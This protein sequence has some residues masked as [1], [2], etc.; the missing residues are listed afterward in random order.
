MN[1]DLELD[2]R[3][4]LVTG[5]TRGIRE[6]VAMRLRE[7]G[8]IVLTT[9]R[10]S[11]RGGLA[12]G[13]GHHHRRRRRG[14]RRRCPRSARGYRHHRPR[15]RRLLG[16]RRLRVLNVSEWHWALDLNLFPAVRLDRALLP[17]MLNQ[18]SGVRVHITSIQRQLPLAARSDPR[19]CRGEGRARELQQGPVQ[20]GEPEGHPR[21]QNLPWLGRDRR[22]RRAG[23]R[24]GGKHGYRLRDR[25]KGLDGFARRHPDR[26]PG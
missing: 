10:S 11:T 8:A 16:A 2:R 18:G 20:G 6:A 22:S 13:G 1:D 5:G 23:Q 21:G 24:A 7:A 15:C 26:T 9:T 14:D 17:T 25:P 12:R 4:A 19:L 3:R